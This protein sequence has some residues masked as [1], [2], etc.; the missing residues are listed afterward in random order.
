MGYAVGAAVV[1]VLLLLGRKQA[2]RGTL[3]DP[4]ALGVTFHGLAG[5]RTYTVAP[6]AG[7]PTVIA[8]YS[9]GSFTVRYPDGRIQLWGTNGRPEGEPY[10]PSREELEVILSAASGGAGGG[11]A[12]W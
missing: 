8:R 1:L 4:G 10:E 12:G 2:P 9:D 3:V 6:E 11:G 5:D 7:E